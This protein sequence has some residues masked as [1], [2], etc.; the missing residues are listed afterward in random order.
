MS[1]FKFINLKHKP[2]VFKEK[3]EGDLILYGDNPNSPYTD[4]LADLYH[5]SP[6][7]STIVNAKLR[8][9]MGGGWTVDTLGVDITK[10]AKANKII[11]NVNQFETLTEVT[12]KCEFDR[13]VFGGFALEVIRDKAGDNI[14]ELYHVD[15]AKVRAFVY[16][17]DELGNPKYKYC[18]LPKWDSKS[19]KYE[20]AKMQP[21][22]KEWFAF[23]D[24]PEDKN[25]LYYYNPYRPC[26]N[27]ELNVYPVPEYVAAIGYIDADSEIQ[28]FHAS[29]IKNNFWGGQFVVMKNVFPSE[30]EQERFVRDFKAQKTGTDNTGEITFVFANGDE[31]TITS[32]PLQPSDLDKQFAQLNDQVRAEIFSVHSVTTPLLFGIRTDSGFGGN[33]DE[34]QTG[35]ELFYSTYV[36]PKQNVWESIINYIYSFN[37]FGRVF[38]L[39]AVKP[40]PYYLSENLIAQLVPHSEL[41]KLAMEQLNIDLSSDISQFSKTPKKDE[42]LEYLRMCGETISEDDILYREKVELDDE[43]RPVKSD[44]Q[45]KKQYFATILGVDLDAMEIDILSAIKSNP[46]VS[47][48]ELSEAFKIPASDVSEIIGKLMENKIL[49]GDVGDLSVGKRAVADLNDEDVVLEVAVRYRYAVRDDVPKAKNGSREYCK[50]LMTLAKAGKV[51]TQKEINTFRNEQGENRNV[52]QYRGGWYTNPNTGETEP[53]CRHYWESLVVKV[54]G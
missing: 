51:Y 48:D 18:Y 10:K 17:Q 1:N 42:V 53:Y 4:Y 9:I 15:F 30:E 36:K 26:K 40:L 44:M 43:G 2:P 35:Y 20:T 37:G 49:T 31:Q 14:K 27:G 28:N 38:T 24:K 45:F 23:W 52:W 33:K 19:M 11:N 39:K 12:E 7:H 50:E 16:E 47:I 41:Q 29:N 5:R 21:G 3:R 46:K 8:Y 25:T 54:K 32:T 34:L 22:F 13:L 6:K